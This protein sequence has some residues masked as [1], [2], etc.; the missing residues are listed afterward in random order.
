MNK[1]ATGDHSWVATSA[2]PHGPDYRWW[3]T[4]T[5]PFSFQGSKHWTKHN[6]TCG[7]TLL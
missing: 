4:G 3:L 7:A 1:Q 5:S 6:W 2:D